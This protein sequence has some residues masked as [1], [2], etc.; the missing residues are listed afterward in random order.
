MLLPALLRL[1]CYNGLITS[2]GDLDKLT[3]RH[4]GYTDEKVSMA[5]DY[6]M[7]FLPML[8][9]KVREFKEIEMTTERTRGVCSSGLNGPIRRK[10]PLKSITFDIRRK[11]SAFTAR[12]IGTLTFGQLTISFRKK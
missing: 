12:R 8:A 6:L 10:R 2:A 11:S 5:I 9:D 1:A 7:G 4:K 3:I